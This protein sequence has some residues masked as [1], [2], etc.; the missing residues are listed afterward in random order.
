M[1]RT[2]LVVLT[3]VLA[4]GLGRA[5]LTCPQPV[6]DA[7]S[8]RSG[9]LLRHRFELRDPTGRARL[10]GVK[11]GCGCL[12]ARL[13]PG[14]PAV[15][16]VAISTATQ[17]AGPNLW[18][19]VV[20]YQDGDQPRELPLY[21]RAELIRELQLTPASLLLHTATP[22]QHAFTLTERRDRPLGIQAA[23]CRSP[24]VRLTAGE[25]RRQADGWVRQVRLEVLPGCPEGRHEDVLTLH[26]DDPL[27]PE[28]KAPFTIVKQS[29]GTVQAAPP[30]VE[31]AAT[32]G[33]PPARLVLL[34]GSDEQPVTIDEAVPS[35][36]FLRCTW[37]SG[38]GPNSTLRVRIDGD[39]VPAGG[40]EGSVRVRLR[41][42]AGPD[43]VLP[44]RLRR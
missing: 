16:Q 27:C 12:E 8:V 22:I 2:L 43:L 14:E 4:P 33:P 32:A 5:E 21:V 13:I 37:A 40:F 23:G 25:P 42:P 30:A 19:A 9:V 10:S 31:F 18:R 7:G 20:R 41:Q 26:T 35:H 39:A 11:A 29:A 34:R 6:H 44:V 17:A 3:A 1:S 24:H 15:V 28:L 38:P 36:P